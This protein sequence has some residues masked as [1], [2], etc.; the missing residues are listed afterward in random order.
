MAHPKVARTF[1]AGKDGPAVTKWGYDNYVDALFFSIS[2]NTFDIAVEK[3]KKRSIDPRK[4]IIVFF[5]LHFFLISSFSFLF[6]LL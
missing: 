2:P 4:K 1:I 3:K 6:L 5:L